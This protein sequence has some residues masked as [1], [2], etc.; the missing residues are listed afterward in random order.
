MS[1][2]ALRS[3]LLAA[4]DRRQALLERLFP[5]AFPTTLMLS[6]NLPGDEKGGARAERLF[7]WGEKALAAA[8]PARLVVRGWDALGPF[9]LYRSPLGT[10]EAKRLA[11]GV[12]TGQ[13]AG[14]LLDLDIFDPSG[15][16]VD[17]AGLGVPP[18]SCLL[19]PE[20]AIACIR[21]GRH[22]GEALKAEARKV[23]DAL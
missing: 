8:F 2:A 23:I 4:R 15:R 18:R 10:R 6:L 3:S 12:E 13:A 14:R 17:R 22:P 19:C 11:M 5:T 21:A 7:A 20:P 16:P 9:A 1:Y